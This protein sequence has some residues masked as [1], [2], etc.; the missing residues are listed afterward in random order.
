MAPRAITL[1][2]Y[3]RLLRSNRNFRRLW[4]AQV[5]SE[6]GDWFYMVSLYAMLLEFTGRAE[7]LGVAFVLQVA[8]QAL[9]GTMA[10]V[11][12][13]RISRKRV[14]IASD[15]ARFVIIALMLLV[16]SPGM[17]WLVWPLL[18]SETVM[19]GLF[20]PARNA[21]LPNIVSP[22][23]LMVANTVT[24]TT[25]SLNLFV[26]SALGGVAAVWLGRDAVFALDALTFL[27]SA[28]LVSGMR[29]VEPH[30]AAA[31]PFRW[32]ELVDQSPLIEAV[33]YVRAQPRMAA[34]MFAKAGLGVAGTSWVVFP[35]LGKRVFPVYRAGSTAEQAGLLGM[36]LLMGARGFGSLLGPILGAPWAQQKPMR[37]RIGI[38]AGF[39]LYGAGYSA[40]AVIT[41]APLAYA[42]II[43][44]HMG[45]AMVWVFSATLLQL[46]V[47]DRFRGRVFAAELAFC[48]TL[49]ALSAYV[50]GV[51]LD[52]G[53][54]VRTVLLVTG[55]L[56]LLAG[57][58]W[59]ALGVR[60]ARSNTESPVE[61]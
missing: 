25:W 54:E 9:T 29:F 45:G 43:L 33:R 21:I 12:N 30:T 26:G 32:R 47:D 37:L 36:S 56:T 13:D 1:A 46:I 22:D 7:V 39:L 4:L 18:F 28:A 16:R 24:S 2:S 19:W 34:V 38:A 48:T 60:G 23:E 49:L 11:V 10:G 44:S 41:S 15:L 55:V 8:P 53:V 42:V 51:V 61:S 14:L 31:Q 17:V 57:V 35:V 50:A 58:G 3:W 27:V 40:L 59:L 6:T 20:E 52:R 5:I